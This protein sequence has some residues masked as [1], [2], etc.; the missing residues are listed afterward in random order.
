MIEA[1]T[2]AVAVNLCVAIDCPAS[3]LAALVNTLNLAID[4]QSIMLPP[5]SPASPLLP[6]SQ[7]IPTSAPPLQPI[8][9]VTQPV[10]PPHTPCPLVFSR[11]CSRRRRQPPLL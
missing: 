10:N 7:V 2:E 3:A 6:L 9:L 5:V 8:I 11:V 4:M 1:E